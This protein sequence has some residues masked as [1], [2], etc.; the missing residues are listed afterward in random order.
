MTPKEKAR[1]LV[2]T[3]YYSLPNNGSQEG[4]NSTTRRYQEAI[5]CALIAVDEIIKTHLLSEK[6]AFGIHPVDYW[7]QVKQQI[8]KLLT[9]G[10]LIK[11]LT[12]I[13]DQDI[14]VMVKG[15]EGGYDDANID[16][17][18]NTPA[19]HYMALNVNTEWYYGHHEKVQDIMEQDL[20]KYQIV[21]AIVL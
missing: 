10:E 5:R 9:V 13:Q 21:K 20:D 4:I 11:A 12:Q 8:N 1:E 14:K 6:N 2:N 19:I 15:Y 3:F 7:Q 18:N 17:D 16:I